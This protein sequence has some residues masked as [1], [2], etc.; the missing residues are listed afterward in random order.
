MGSALETLCGQA[1]GAGQ[2]NMLGIY[3]Q[4]SW[5]IT[6]TTAL[7][8]TP[9][10]VFTSP[11]LK[12]LHQDNHIA[13]LAG[14]FSI[15]VLPQL[16]AYAVN[17]PT[18]KFLQSQSKVWV[19]TIISLVSLILHTMLSWLF[20]VKLEH[21]LFGAALAGN[22]TWWFIVVTQIGYVVSGYFP[23]A[24]TGVSLQAF[25]SLAGFVK[26]SLASAIMLWYG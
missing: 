1:V 7:F 19:M 13:E 2:L 9:F 25:K 24:W 23:E 3:M 12:F 20:I 15:W 16:F 8:L 14:K 6:A 10:Y 17:F 26:L 4:R 5:I 18:Q 22:I 11:I 21:G